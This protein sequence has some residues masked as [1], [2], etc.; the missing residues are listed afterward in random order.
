MEDAVLSYGMEGPF[1]ESDVI[2]ASDLLDLLPD[3]EPFDTIADALEFALDL[4]GVPNPSIPTAVGLF[5]VF[6]SSTP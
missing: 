2:S 1:F 4:P 3:V 5:K 6:A